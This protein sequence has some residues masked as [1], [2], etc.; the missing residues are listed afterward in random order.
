M[1]VSCGIIFIIHSYRDAQSELNFM[2]NYRAYL[3]DAVTARSAV[4]V[5]L[6]TVIVT[7]PKRYERALWLHISIGSV[8]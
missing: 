6:I 1:Y 5:H 3:T 7:I 2:T 8:R 4:M